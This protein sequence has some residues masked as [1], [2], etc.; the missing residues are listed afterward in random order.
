[1]PAL[2][3]ATTIELSVPS[4]LSSMPPMYALPALSKAPVGSLQ[5][6]PTR[7]S[8]RITWWNGGLK[9]PQDEPPSKLQSNPHWLYPRRESFCPAMMF[10][11]F[12]GFTAS[13]SSACRRN[14]Q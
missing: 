5:K 11:V 14:E 12:V 3:L 4:R 9:S 10:L 13:N 6:S 8:A 1:M 2:D 7:P